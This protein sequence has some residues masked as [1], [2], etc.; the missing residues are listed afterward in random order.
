[1][2]DILCLRP[3]GGLCNRLR[4]LA[5]ALAVCDVL[6]KSLCLEWGG[7]DPA[8][9]GSFDDLFGRPRGMV[10]SRT[11][12]PVLEGKWGNAGAESYRRRFLPD[13]DAEEFGK[14][15][16]GRMGELSPL[17]CLAEEIGRLKKGISPSTIGV[18]VRRTDLLIWA[19]NE[20]WPIDVAE[21]DRLL[22]ERLDRESPETSFFVAAD[23]P[24]SMEKLLER[25]GDRVIMNEALWLGEGL[26]KTRVEDAVIDLYCLAGCS[27]LVGTYWSSF[28]DY[29]ALLGGIPC[30]H[31]AVPDFG[32][33]EPLTPSPG[34][35]I[36]VPMTG[37]VLAHGKALEAVNRNR[38]TWSSWCGDLVWVT[39]ED[40]PVPWEC[41]RL[42]ASAHDGPDNVARQILACKLAA[43]CERAVVLE[44]DTL[45]FGS[46]PEPV[47]GTVLVSQAFDD[48]SNPTWDQCWKSRFYGHSP[49][50][51]TREDWGRIATCEIG[52]EKGFP[53]RWMAAAAI[54]LGLRLEG[55]SH[56][57][58]EMVI[59]TM[60]GVSRAKAAMSH[61]IAAIH[62][63][64]NKWVFD[65]ITGGS[66][67]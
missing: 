63:V 41:H 38:E 29:A 56:G 42:G 25:Y 30:E 64:K 32:L 35:D 11:G 31:I 54:T 37:I 1:M 61:G 8:C 19:D 3:I 66:I 65:R 44:Y 7:G 50:L 28:S 15:V 33:R 34:G 45:L 6:G 59:E 36:P 2:N 49:W 17:P 14:L 58:S 26:R 53:D 12:V 22:M 46:P 40:D 9:P 55:L 23:N 18:H 16:L 24:D 43:G 21:S 67:S 57:Y 48:S 52:I 13:M 60:D 47:P 10:S 62:G 39:P 4:A 27:R 5:P 51:C 20:H